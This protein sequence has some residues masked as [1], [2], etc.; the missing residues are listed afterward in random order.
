MSPE[1]SWKDAGIG[2][3]RPDGQQYAAMRIHQYPKDR[4]SLIQDRAELYLA[5][6][7]RTLRVLIPN[8]EGGV[9][10]YAWTRDGKQVIYWRADEWSASI[11]ADGIRLYAIPATGGPE[12]KLGVSSLVH[13]DMLDLALL[14]VISS[15]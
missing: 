6:E 4:Y 8:H 13:A 2:P 3:F 5:T 12:R 15:S 10:P 9:R 14:L 7:D 1:A 11:W